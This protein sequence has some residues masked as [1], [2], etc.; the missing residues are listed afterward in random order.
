LS[1]ISTEQKENNQLALNFSSMIRIKHFIDLTALK[2]AMMLAVVCLSGC[3]RGND[4][5]EQTTKIIPVKVLTIGLSDKS[6]SRS[7]VGTVEESTAISLSFSSLGTVEQVL[8]AE[9][10]Q[11]QKGQLLATLNSVSAQSSLDAVQSTLDR[12]QDAYDRM[13]KLHANGSLPDIKFEEVKSGLQQSKSMA[14]IARKNLND[15]KLYAPRGGVIAVRSIE[16]GAN[17]MP[18]M[19]VFKLVMVDNVL[20]KISI[21]EN[22]ISGIAKGQEA[23]VEIPALAQ[24]SFSGKVELK[25]VSANSISHTYDVKIGISN[26]QAELMPGMACKAY[27]TATETTSEIVVPNRTVQISHDGKHFVWLAENGVARR[28]FITVGNLNE[29]GVGIV[30]GLSAGDQLIAEGYVKV[31][32]GMKIKIVE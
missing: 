18:G 12:A 22:E 15:C 24:K 7:Y 3:G 32:E 20:V 27:L 26:P 21:P 2:A 31:S 28:R 8:V 14:E 19:A 5:V 30:S 25:G 1:P 29:N 6:N 4:V 10:Q 13:V 17:I 23:R 16:S 11:V 9:G